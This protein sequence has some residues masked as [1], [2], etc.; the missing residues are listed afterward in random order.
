MN[1]QVPPENQLYSPS[2]FSLHP[3][4]KGARS[5]W[6]GPAKSNFA[7]MEISPRSLK[8]PNF[9]PLRKRASPP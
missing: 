3:R 6:N 5:S 4:Q 9:E 8:K 1:P 7:G 2:C